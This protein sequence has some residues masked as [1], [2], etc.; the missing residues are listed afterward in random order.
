VRAGASALVLAA[1]AAATWGGY[2]IA[3][4]PRDAELA[5]KLAHAA[6]LLGAGQVAA[7]DQELRALWNAGARRPGVA[8]DLAVAAYYAKRLG[9]CALWTERGRRLDPRQPVAS[10]LA[11]ALAQ[12]DAW[13][14]LPVGV[15]A[16]TTAGELVVAGLVFAALALFAFAFGG[17]G[18][19]GIGLA[20]CVLALAALGMGARE[21]FVGQA[22]GRAIVIQETPLA[23]APN[24]PG[25][26]TLEAGRAV[27]L[28]EPAG[29]WQH[30]RVSPQ[31]DGFVPRRAVTAI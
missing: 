14:G 29:T 19:R 22:P 11:Q 15:L 30:V 3:T 13:E 5:P 25:N 28:L 18:L 20:L 24:G 9:E 2:A 7:G 16:Q 17:R 12:Q 8:F 21:A 10:D 31:V 4:A 6:R 27:W 1:L 26:V 23:D